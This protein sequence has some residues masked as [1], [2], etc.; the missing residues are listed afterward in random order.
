[1]GY[2]DCFVLCLLL[3][4]SILQSIETGTTA[5]GATAAYRAPDAEVDKEKDEPNYIIIVRFILS[6]VLIPIKIIILLTI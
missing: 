6:F 4:D 2:V 3:F 5:N 1:M